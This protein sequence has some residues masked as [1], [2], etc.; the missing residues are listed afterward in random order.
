M[1]KVKIF[2][3]LLVT[4]ICFSQNKEILYNFTPLPQ[5]LLTNPGA[6]VKY[7]WFF[8]VP[9][10]SGISANVG[11]TGIN[12]FD[13]F[14]K[15][16][17]DFNTKVEKVVASTNRNDYVTTNQ[18]L[19]LFS[20]G[21]RVGGPENKSYISFGM[22]QEFDSFVYI[23]TDVVLLSIYGNKDY[24][25]K[26][27]NLADL[28]VKAELLSVFHAGINKKINEKLTVGARGKIYSSL[29]NATSTH[30]AGYF[31]TTLGTDL[32]YDQSIR[33][34]LRLNTSGVKKYLDENYNG[35]FASDLKDDLISKTFL[36]GNLGLGFD[37]GLTYNPKKNIQITA[38]LVD[39]GYIKHTK[40]VEN[41]TLKGFYNFKGVITN[42]NQDGTPDDAY[43]DFED[44]IP[45]DTLYTSYN[46]QRPLKFYSSF[47]YSFEEERQMEC[48]CD[49][50]EDSWYR[51]AIGA[52]LFA[53]TTPRAPMMAL[54]AYYR[55]RLLD[56]LQIKATYT[57]D[58]YSYT[59]V[60]LGLY[61]K[62]GVANFYVLADNLLG[63]ADL[64]KTN[65][66]S[67]QIGFN[68]ISG[69]SIK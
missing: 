68:I 17:V 58:S 26:S 38:S 48:N 18:Q 9:L 20:G 46:T 3:C 62:I 67:F 1:I 28:N 12:A 44:A 21:F 2:L 22:Y 36:G 60:G 29:Y 47:Q 55:R 49:T 32:I 59:N 37:V 69:G 13:L 31:S 52:Q 23:P 64:A 61:T 50:D 19:E 39:I 11:S 27:F 5:S 6:D 16:G 43:Q 14:A 41:F 10:L 4:V 40:E 34:N 35:D 30:N 15:D 51:S 63:Y 57:L 56:G 42:F 25:G 66:L 45:L 65:A 7:K 33:S 24:I 54:T 8:G 53:M